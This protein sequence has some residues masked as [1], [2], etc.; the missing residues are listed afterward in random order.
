LSKA[1]AI[2]GI[3]LI[4][5]ILPL[6]LIRYTVAKTDELLSSITGGFLGQTI[7]ITEFPVKREYF[8]P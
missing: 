3:V 5:C 7:P 8:S 1:N 2:W 6:T 4:I